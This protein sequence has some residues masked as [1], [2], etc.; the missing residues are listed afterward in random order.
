M[1]GLDDAATL[2]DSASCFYRCGTAYD[3]HVLPLG[4]PAFDL[5][6]LSDSTI[7]PYVG[8]FDVKYTLHILIIFAMLLQNKV[9]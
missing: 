4:R 2:I 9:H 8:A 3:L 1:S 7:T 6:K 5:L